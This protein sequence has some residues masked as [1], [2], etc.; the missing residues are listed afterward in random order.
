MTFDPTKP[1]QTRDGRKA[2]IIC[3]DANNHQPIVALI[4]EQD[5]HEYTRDYTKDGF[6]FM[7]SEQSSSDLINI[8]ERRIMWTNVYTLY[9]DSNYPTREEADK[10]AGANRIGVLK[11]TYENDEK[12]IRLVDHEYEKLK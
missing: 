3:T 6:Y 9:A 4:T 11:I 8:P 10:H 7:C 1:V 2:R 12:G 5:G